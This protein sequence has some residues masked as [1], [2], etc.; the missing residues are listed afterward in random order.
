MK[1]NR[2]IVFGAVTIV[3]ILLS[4][5]FFFSRN[6]ESLPIEKGSLIEAIYALGVV[7]PELDYSLKFGI[8]SSIRELYVKE[9]DQVKANDPLLSNDSGVVFHSPIAGIVT[10]LP[11]SKG[12][13]IMPGIVLAEVMNW[14]KVY[15]QVFL[16]QESAIRVKEGQD[17]TLS[18]ESLRGHSYKAKVEKI[19]PSGGQFLVR[20][21]PEEMPPGILPEMTTD[22]AIQVAKR[23]NTI[24]VPLKGVNNGKVLRIRNGKKEKI[25]IKLGAI[26]EEKGELLSGDLIEGD[27]IIINNK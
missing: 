6:K 4:V 10:K 18:F 2:Y 14:E 5:I 7:K 23:E 26:N 27:E 9:G 25:E 3:I 12:E 13:T 19:Y 8:S 21:I 1:L 20:L 24:L 15:I 22:L 11:Y 16:E 17:A